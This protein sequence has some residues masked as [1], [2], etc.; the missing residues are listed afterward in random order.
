VTESSRN[1]LRNRLFLILVISA[2]ACAALYFLG[3]LLIQS[4]ILVGYI[5]MVP[6]ILAWEKYSKNDSGVDSNDQQLKEKK[7][8]IEKK[9][10]PKIK[11][12]VKEK[13][14]KKI[15]KKAKK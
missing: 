11:K 2:I 9:S 7:K 8:E 4:I 14:E 10:E 15:T 5:S 6:A 12:E 1:Q 13:A 3:F